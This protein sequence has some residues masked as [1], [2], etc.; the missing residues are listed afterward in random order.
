MELH[1]V[2][3]F[4]LA[5]EIGFKHMIFK[6]DLGRQPVGDQKPVTETAYDSKAIFAPE[7]G[8]ARTSHYV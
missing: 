1:V 6:I 5:K 8:I 2:G 4:F 7:V 3:V